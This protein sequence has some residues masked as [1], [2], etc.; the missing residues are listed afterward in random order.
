MPRE[1]PASGKRSQEDCA[2]APSQSQL[3]D[4]AAVD[5]AAVV[6][7]LNDGIYVCDLDR[8]NHLLEQIG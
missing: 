5:I 6:D 4:I 7:S 1:V 8:T 3:D 2:G